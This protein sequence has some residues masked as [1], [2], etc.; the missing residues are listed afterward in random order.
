MELKTRDLED[1]R[2]TLKPPLFQQLHN[3]RT[4]G[5]SPR[6]PILRQLPRGGIGDTGGIRVKR[7]SL[8]LDSGVVAFEDGVY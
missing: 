4:H 7:L 3:H 8:L 1:P 2:P 6:L 5:L